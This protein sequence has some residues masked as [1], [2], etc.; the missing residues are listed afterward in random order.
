MYFVKVV[1]AL[2][3]AFLFSSSALARSPSIVC[4]EYEKLIKSLDRVV[5]LTQMWAANDRSITKGGSCAWSY[6]PRDGFTAYWHSFYINKHGIIFPIFSLKYHGE[7]GFRYSPDI[8]QFDSEFYRLS[9]R[10]RD[11]TV[12]QL[13]TFSYCLVPKKPEYVHNFLRSLGTN[14]V[15]AYVNIPE[16]AYGWRH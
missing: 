6:P 14:D 15:P 3:S 7:A 9:D 12:Q 10:R 11:C 4:F 1:F 16:A 2:V 8:F 5:A 13:R